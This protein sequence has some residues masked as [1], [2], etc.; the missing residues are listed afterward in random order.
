MSDFV[1]FCFCIAV[2]LSGGG[3]LKKGNKC[4]VGGRGNPGC[5]S[6]YLSIIQNLRPGRN[7]K[8]IAWPSAICACVCVW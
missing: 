5:V 7:K 6:S 8:Y 3:I 4:C 1:L 2:L